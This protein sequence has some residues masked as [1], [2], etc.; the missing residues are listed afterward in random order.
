MSIWRQN[1]LNETDW[2]SGP[3]KKIIAPQRMAFLL[4]QLFWVSIP[5]PLLTPSGLGVVTP[6]LYCTIL[7]DF[8]PPCLYFV[9]GARIDQD[10]NCQ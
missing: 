10:D 6:P 1:A 3:L 5:P 9:T 7:Y 4:R 8:P 2:V